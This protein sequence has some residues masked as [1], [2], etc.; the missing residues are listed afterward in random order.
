MINEQDAF[1]PTRG[2]LLSRLKDWNDQDS[3]RDFFD[4]YWKLIYSTARKSGLSDAEAQDVVQDTVITVAK[5]ISAF[6]R[7]PAF[8]SFKGWLRAVTRSRIVD[9]VRKRQR[10]DQPKPQRADSTRRTATIE[11]VPDPNAADLDADWETEWQKNMVDAALERIKRKVKP[12]HYQLFELHV[13]KGWPV[14]KVV[15]TVGVN[16]SQIYLVT[17]RITKLLKKEI[18]RLEKQFI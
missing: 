18:T 6:K 10:A 7:D 13:I 16:R 15:E 3:W 17:H 14:P 12:Q 8:G 11:R 4:T 9:L 2:S 1:I 5:K